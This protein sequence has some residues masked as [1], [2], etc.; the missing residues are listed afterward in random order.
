MYILICIFLC[1]KT[2]KLKNINCPVGLSFLAYGYGNAIGNQFVLDFYALL[3]R[4]DVSAVLGTTT[5]SK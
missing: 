5:L 1:Y 4:L 3:I 2:V